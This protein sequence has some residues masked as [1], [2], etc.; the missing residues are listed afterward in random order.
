MLLQEEETACSGVLGYIPYSILGLYRRLKYDVRLPNFQQN[1]A[2]GS[3][4]FLLLVLSI[5]SSV[6]D[7]L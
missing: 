4:A 7:H 2:P 5:V 6:I 1:K 3:A